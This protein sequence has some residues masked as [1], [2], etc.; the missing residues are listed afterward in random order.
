VTLIARL[1]PNSEAAVWFGGF[2][3]LVVAVFLAFW[4]Y[5]GA[6]IVAKKNYVARFKR[7]VVA[8]IATAVAPFARYEPFVGLDQHVFNESGLFY[9]GGE[10][11]SD[12]R[13]RGRIGRTPFGRPRS[14]E[15]KVHSN[16]ETEARGLVTATMVE[17]LLEL[18]NQIGYPLSCASRGIA[19]LSAF[20]MAGNCSSLALL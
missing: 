4:Q 1:F 19:S 17:R 12:D 9:S 11:S 13:M 7:E 16:V 8:D 15:F 10:Y 2:G 5:G 6:A 20:T 14:N 3:I 18:R